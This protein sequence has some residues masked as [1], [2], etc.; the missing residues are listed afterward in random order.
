[1]KA[2]FL[3]RDGVINPLVYDAEHGL[4]DSPLNPSQFEL[5]PEAIEGLRLINDAAIP[6]FLISNQPGI[7][8]GKMSNSLFRDIDAKMTEGLRRAG[9]RLDG[10]YYCL[11]HPQAVLDNYRIDCDCRKPNP[12]LLLKAAAEHRIDLKK[13]FM[14][15]DGLN[16]I[17]AGKRL[18]C[19]TIL[20]G[21]ERCDRCQKIGDSDLGPDFI[22][23]DLN[24]AAK[25]VIKE[26]S[27]GNFYR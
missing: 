16:D 9:C 6:A 2:I 4:I 22:A 5:I 20:I 3:D 11:H 1:M 27:Y 10:I 21:G 14:I 25:L 17:E 23:V 7:A 24:E 18:G 19:R 8:K 13:S 15:G 26:E 12:G